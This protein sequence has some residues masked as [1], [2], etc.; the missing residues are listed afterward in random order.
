MQWGSWRNHGLT[1]STTD[2]WKALV[3][4]QDSCIRLFR[5]GMCPSTRLV[6]FKYCR[7]NV[8][9]HNRARIDQVSFQEVLMS[10]HD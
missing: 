6:E 5:R 8:S 9:I 7:D 1:S 2:E 4:D 3:L 10:L